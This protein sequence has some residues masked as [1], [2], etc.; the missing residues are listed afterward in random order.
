[1][2]MNA[3]TKARV[4]WMDQV[5]DINIMQLVMNSHNVRIM[6]IGAGIAGDAMDAR[7]VSKI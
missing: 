5:A 3:L 1:M 7:Q 6:R 4:R 2:G